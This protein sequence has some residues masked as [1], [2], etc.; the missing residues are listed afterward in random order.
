MF[1]TVAGVIGPTL[2]GVLFE[3]V[4]DGAPA[5]VAAMLC[6]AAVASIGLLW[7]GEHTVDG[8]MITAKAQKE[9]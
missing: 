1:G 9:E 6:A 8:K 3:R 4:G 7:N 5:A 2:S